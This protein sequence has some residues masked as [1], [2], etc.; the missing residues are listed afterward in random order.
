MMPAG[1]GQPN[2]RRKRLGHIALGWPSASQHPK[3]R[4]ATCN[5]SPPI[6]WSLI[7]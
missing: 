5:G 2:P 1:I 3:T 4:Y 7:P 6:P